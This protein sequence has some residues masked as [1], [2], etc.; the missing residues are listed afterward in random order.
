MQGRVLLEVRVSAEG[1]PLSVALRSSSGFDL[2]DQAAAEAVRKW[3]FV[4]ARR[5]GRA[6][7]ALVEIPIRF[8]L[9]EEK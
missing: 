2:L 6:V 8:V 9:A 1:L 4:P 7:E 5:G 3:R